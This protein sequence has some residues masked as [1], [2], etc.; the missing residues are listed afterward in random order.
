[1]KLYEFIKVSQGNEMFIR[2]NKNGL[3]APLF[4]KHLTSEPIPAELLEREIIKIAPVPVTRYDRPAA[5]FQ[6][7]LA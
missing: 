7:Y 2:G 5:A 1:M 3:D 6:I 4:H